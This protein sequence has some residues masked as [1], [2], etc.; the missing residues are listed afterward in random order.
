MYHK[1]RG[2]GEHGFASIRLWSKLIF[3]YWS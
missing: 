1:G 3:Y 2:I